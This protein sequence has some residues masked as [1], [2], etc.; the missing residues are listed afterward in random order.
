ML[1]KSDIL[2]TVRM[3]QEENLDV[4]TVTMGVNL[5]E[6][7]GRDMKMTAAAVQKKLK[8]KAGNLVRICDELSARYGLPV[9]NKRLAVS[10]ASILLEGHGR[11]DAVL[12]AKAMDNAAAEVNVDLIGGF[13]ALVQ[14]E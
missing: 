4:R 13:T 11:N 3:L 14:K 6:C 1:R 10:P 8:L 5:L 7:A 2:S 9:V 12:L